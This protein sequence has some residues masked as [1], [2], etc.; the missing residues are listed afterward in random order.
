MRPYSEASLEKLCNMDN[1]NEQNSILDIM[2]RKMVDINNGE[3]SDDKQN[4]TR[5]DTSVGNETDLPKWNSTPSLIGSS[6][7]VSSP[8]SLPSPSCK[9][10]KIDCA[11]CGDKSSGKHYGVHTCEGC[12][13]FFKRSIR[14]NLEYQCRSNKKCPVD[15][16][17]RNQC[18]H[19]RLKKC[20]NVGMKREAVQR[21]RTSVTDNNSVFMAQDSTFSFTL[22]SQLTGAEPF[23][24]ISSSSTTNLMNNVSQNMCEIATKLLFNGIEWAKNIPFFPTLSFTDQIA[25]VKL[26]WKELFVLNLGK[27]EIPFHLTDLLNSNH[28]Q[29]W[30]E[31]YATFCDHVKALQYQIEKLRHLQID[32]SEYACLKAL[33]LFTPDTPG[34]NNFAYIHTLQEKAMN[35]LESYTKTK[36]PLQ[37]ARFGKLL[38]RLSSIR[39]INTV[40]IEQL[41]F[42]WLV[43]KTP[44]ETIIQDYMFGCPSFS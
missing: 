19:C 13:S 3:T 39:T 18:Q 38:L 9:N 7:S 29:G 12:K 15:Q 42:T 17:H 44:I 32:A 22:I 30:S 23:Q 41:F 36:Y 25:L 40:V 26:G 24:P 16:H 8:A 28:L 27:C 11:V 4:S 1:S 5:P 2:L 14:R 37:P 6:S 21:G 33:I 10:T 20:F 43:G 35:A 34:L 31:Y